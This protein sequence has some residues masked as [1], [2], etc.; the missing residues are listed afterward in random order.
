MRKHHSFKQSGQPSGPYSILTLTLSLFFL[1][2]Q[3][4]KEK[5][6]ELVSKFG[7]DFE[8]FYNVRNV[9]KI[10]LQIQINILNFQEY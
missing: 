10:L 3:I 7:L 9:L 2:A 1:L 5:S 8:L 6:S 4:E